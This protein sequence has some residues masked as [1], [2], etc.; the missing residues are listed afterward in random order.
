MCVCTH[1]CAIY[2]CMLL[3]ALNNRMGLFAVCDSLGCHLLL[4]LL[5]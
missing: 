4:L 5:P 3:R 1:M 2:V